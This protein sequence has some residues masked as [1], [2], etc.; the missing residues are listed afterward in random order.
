MPSS[1]MRIA[2]WCLAALTLHTAPACA[3]FDFD[4]QVIKKILAAMLKQNHASFHATRPQFKNTEEMQDYLAQTI[5]ELCAGTGKNEGTITLY[6]HS[7]KGF[8]ESSEPIV[9]PTPSLKELFAAKI[10]DGL[11]PKDFVCV[12]T[13]KEHDFQRILTIPVTSDTQDSINKKLIDAGYTP[14]TIIYLGDSMHG[15]QRGE[16]LGEVLQDPIRRHRALGLLLPRIAAG[17]SPKLLASKA[18]RALQLYG[19]KRYKQSA[20]VPLEKE[21]LSHLTTQQPFAVVGKQTI[22]WNVEDL[23]TVT[24]QPAMLML[25]KNNAVW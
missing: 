4:E 16:M 21:L 6:S 19:G 17:K 9:L 5:N 22:E 24:E 20:I 23:A 3:F 2:L 8:F 25:L 15:T 13:H 14:E 1:C 11:N 18:L 7:E 12:V 10:A